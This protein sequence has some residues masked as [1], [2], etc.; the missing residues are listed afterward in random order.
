MSGIRYLLLAG[1]AAPALLAT[2][3]ARAEPAGPVVLGPSRA[4]YDDGPDTWRPARALRVGAADYLVTGAAVAV[5]FG[6][7]GLPPGPAAW[8][9]GILMDER[10]R[11]ALRLRTAEGRDA[12]LDASDAGLA[13]TT[14]WPFFAD[15]LVSAWWYRG[16]ADVAYHMTVVSAEAFAIATAL[17][18]VAN[19][20]GRRERPYGRLCGGGLPD[21]SIDCDR[22][23]RDRSF[24]SGHATVAFTG[25]SLLCAHHLGLGLLG[26]PGDVATCVGGAVVA[27]STSM[28]RVMSDMHYV[29]DIALGAVVGTAVGLAV[30]ILHMRR[31]TVRSAGPD[32]RLA[33]VGTGVGVVGEF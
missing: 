18:G 11:S 33:P 15:A 12:A 20:V 7:A 14:A 6:A 25:A 19:H 21:E 16:R 2:S 5:T 8:R 26:P 3:A 22:G 30:P 29:T 23:V 31:A 4:D 1:A 27:A 32:V 10:A 28:L 17:Q 9:G 13:L 24:F